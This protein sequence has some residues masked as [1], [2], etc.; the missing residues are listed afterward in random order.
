[1]PRAERKQ[2]KT[3]IYHIMLRGINKQLIFEETEDYLKFLS[4]LSEVKRISDFKLY[5]YCLMGNHVHLLMKEGG[6]P[7]SQI[8][9]RLGARYVFWFNW[10]Y[11]RTGHLF[12]DRFKSEPIESDEHFIMALIYIYQNPVKAELCKHPKDYRWSSRKQLGNCEIIDESELSNIVQIESIKVKEAE[13]IRYEFMEPG[14]GRRMAMTDDEAFARVKSISGVKS[15]MEFQSLNRKAQGK[16][17]AEL[18][19][20]GASQRQLARLTGLSRAVV[21][22]LLQSVKEEAG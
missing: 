19:R 15:V 8:F 21:V 16:A 10:K 9:R 17:F 18:S 13:E 3:G 22:R 14:I 5:A 12:Q 2:S 6:E 20:L 7:L 1:M 11:E 4:F